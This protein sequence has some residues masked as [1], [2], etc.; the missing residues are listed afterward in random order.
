MRASNQAISE[1]W[2][3]ADKPFTRM[4]VDRHFASTADALR[5]AGIRKAQDIPPDLRTATIFAAGT[6][7]NEIASRAAYRNHVPVF[8]PG[9]VVSREQFA[10]FVFQ[11]LII[12]GFFVEAQMEGV[13]VS[14]ADVGPAFMLSSLPMHTQQQQAEIAVEG[15]KIVKQIMAQGSPFTMDLF[16]LARIFIENV[17][18]QGIEVPAMLA[19]SSMDDLFASMLTSLTKATS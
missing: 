6:N 15:G 10:A 4:L 8:M 19:G 2:A 5:W 1:R 17:P 13:E 9:D 18:A 11:L 3:V 14:G 12:L 16:K 7:A